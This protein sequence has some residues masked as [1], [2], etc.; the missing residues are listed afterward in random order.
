MKKGKKKENY[1]SRSRIKIH[2]TTEYRIQINRDAVWNSPS[3]ACMRQDLA[4]VGDFL[5]FFSVESGNTP[6]SICFI[7]FMFP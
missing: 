4:D 7:N 6:S 1:N 2:R 5:F 3:P